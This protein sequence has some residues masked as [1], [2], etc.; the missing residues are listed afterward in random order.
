M[1]ADE[2]K[3]LTLN[4]A[5]TVFRKEMSTIKYKILKIPKNKLITPKLNFT[6][7]IKYA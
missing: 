7:A 2:N 6:V 5:H 3:K 4:V 1:H